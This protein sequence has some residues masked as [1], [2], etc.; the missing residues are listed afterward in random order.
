[1]AEHIIDVQSPDNGIVLLVNERQ[2]FYALSYG[3]NPKG[4]DAYAYNI[5]FSVRVCQIMFNCEG[6]PCTHVFY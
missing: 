3:Q 4:R 2:E 1:M 6:Y 5:N